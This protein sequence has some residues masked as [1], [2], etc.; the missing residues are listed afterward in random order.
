MWAKKEITANK[1]YFCSTS[2][3]SHLMPSNRPSSTSL[4]RDLYDDDMCIIRTAP[5]LVLRL[6]W[7]TLARHTSRWIKPLDLNVCP[8]LSSSFRQFCGITDKPYPTWFW[9]QTKKPSWWFYGSN[10]QIAPVGFE[11]QTGKPVDLS[12]EAELRNSLSSSP[13]ARCRLHITSSDLSIIRPPSTRPM[14]DHPRSF[15]PSFYSCLNPCCCPP[16]HT[17]HLHIMK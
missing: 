4:S 7:K 11:A 16:Y 5:S 2:T 17:Y 6:D 3:A 12:F 14:F 10:H 15:V 8:T 9:G 1:R 13:C